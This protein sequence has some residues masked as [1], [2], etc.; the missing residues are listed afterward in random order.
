MKDK[1]IFPKEIKK[2]IKNEGSKMVK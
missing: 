2:E 1:M